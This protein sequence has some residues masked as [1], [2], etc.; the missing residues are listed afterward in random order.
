M[1]TAEK[2]QNKQ[3]MRRMN[4]HKKTI[5]FNIIFA[6]FVFFFVDGTR[7]LNFRCA[8]TFSMS[9]SVSLR[10]LDAF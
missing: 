8:I 3:Q 7:K 6:L 4:T 10:V 1:N 5:L 9:V 2:M